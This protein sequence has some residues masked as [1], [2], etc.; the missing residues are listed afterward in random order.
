MA[1]GLCHI[2][3][4]DGALSFEHVP[5]QSAFNDRP[6]IRV[7]LESVVRDGLDAEPTGRPDQRGAGAFTLCPSCNSKTGGWYGRAFAEWCHDGYDIL[8]RTGGST[9]YLIDTHDMYP[10]RVLKQVVTMF[11][12]VNGPDFARDYPDLVRFV[13]DKEQRYLHPRYRIAVY[14]N[15]IGGMRRTPL[16]R[17]VNIYSRTVS[18]FSEIAHFPFGYVLTVDSDVWDHRLFDITHFSRYEYTERRWVTMALPVLATHL[19][20]PGDY[21]P[22]PQIRRESEQRTA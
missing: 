10:L 9:G 3:G 8:M 6:I 4:N 15:P 2:C 22:E 12:S 21:R 18:D 13:L 1:D 14:F 7:A 20:W 17:M 19:P 16:S 11:F 5:P